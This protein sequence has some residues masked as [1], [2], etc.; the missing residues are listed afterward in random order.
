MIIAKACCLDKLLS[1][2]FVGLKLLHATMNPPVCDESISAKVLNREVLPF[3]S[4][5]IEKVQQLNFKAKEVSLSALVNIF[6]H[7]HVNVGVLIAKLIEFDE[8]IDK[9]SWRVVLGRL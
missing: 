4:L 9:L 5:L 2:Y 8:R 3:I 1:V 6:N 7:P